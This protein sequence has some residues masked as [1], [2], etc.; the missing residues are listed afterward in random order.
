M[1]IYRRQDIA[2]HWS[3]AAIF[4]Q[5]KAQQGNIFRSKEGRRTLQ[6]TLADKPYFLKYHEG[7][8]WGE[9]VKNL[10]QLRLPIISAKSEWQAIHF[11]EAQGLATLSI[12]AYGERGWNPAKINSF[13]VT[14][15]LTKTMSLEYLSTQWRA[16]P[17]TFQTKKILI[18]KLANI[19]KVMHENGMNH[20]DFYLCHFLLDE[21]FADDNTITAETALHLIDL[22]RAQIRKKT[23]RRWKVKDLGSLYY[24]AV[25]V[26]LTQRDL[27]RFMVAYLGGSARQVLQDMSLWHSVLG[28]SQKLQQR[29]RHG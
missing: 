3:E 4:E 21:K 19:A 6:F 29:E 18:E 15:A 1:T 7:V 12:A 13:L 28:R 5:V 11:L 23:P 14:D 16:K 26:P 25:N 22:H 20:R 9:I 10:L 8:G 27:L 2:T 24:S 17:P